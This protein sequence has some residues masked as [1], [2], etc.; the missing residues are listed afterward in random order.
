MGGGTNK[1][2]NKIKTFEAEQL[3]WCWG[4]RVNELGMRVN[5]RFRSFSNRGSGGLPYQTNSNDP[6]KSPSLGD[7]EDILNRIKARIKN[8]KLAKQNKK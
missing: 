5:E 3:L 4:A 2:L 1:F 6:R 8:K 7:S